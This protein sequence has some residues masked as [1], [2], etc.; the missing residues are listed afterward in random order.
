MAFRLLILFFFPSPSPKTHPSALHQNRF[1]T[2]SCLTPAS[3]DFGRRSSIEARPG[4][5]DRT[6]R[7]L[8]LLKALAPMLLQRVHEF[9]PQ[10]EETARLSL[11]VFGRRAF[12]EARD[13]PFRSS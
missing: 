8:R 12:G 7:P 13:R 9:T 6:T 10:G 11:A 1:P 5:D 2:H 4:R 3:A